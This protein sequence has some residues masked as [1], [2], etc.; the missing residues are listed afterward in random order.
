MKALAGLVALL[1]LAAIGG[2]GVYDYATGDFGILSSKPVDEAT[3]CLKDTACTPTPSEE[4]DCCTTLKPS[5]CTVVKPDCC[6]T[7]KN[8]CE[9]EKP[10]ASPNT[11]AP[12]K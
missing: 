5:C 9:T 10:A 1:A 11:P 12:E 7:E 2:L 4:P 3:P 8:C 6:A